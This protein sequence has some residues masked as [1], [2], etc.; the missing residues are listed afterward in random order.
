MLGGARTGRPLLAGDRSDL[1][2]R[3]SLGLYRQDRLAGAAASAGAGDPLEAGLG[4]LAEASALTPLEPR[5]R[6]L[7]GVLAL[8]YDDK[9]EQARRAFAIQRLLEPTWVELPLIQADSWLKIDAGETGALWKLAMERARARD[10]I[11]P[12]AHSRRQVFEQILQRA[13][14]S[15]E[16]MHFAREA[17]GGDPTLL[18]RAD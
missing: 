7:E 8:H 17:A 5:I 12:A 4:K 3:E 11:D 1:L 13:R 14:K 6:G 18:D 9:D 16:L 10:L 2:F 15:P